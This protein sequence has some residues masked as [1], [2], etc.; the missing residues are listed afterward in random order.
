MVFGKCGN[1]G[2]EWSGRCGAH[3]E[4]EALRMGRGYVV[5]LVMEVGEYS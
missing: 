4:E 1:F 3:D 5:G 2:A